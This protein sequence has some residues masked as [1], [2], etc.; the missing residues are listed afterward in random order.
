[1][2]GTEYPISRERT[3]ELMGFDGVWEHTQDAVASADYMLESSNIAVMSLNTLARLAEDI[4]FW[5]TNEAEFAGLSDDLIDSSSIMP[6]KRN[7][8]IAPPSAPR[9][10]SSP[11]ATRASV[12][13]VASS[14]RPAGT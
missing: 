4:I 3:G 6:Q 11:A 8:V 5:C 14:S 2:S 10:G 7:P 1:M 12:T 9:P 13:P